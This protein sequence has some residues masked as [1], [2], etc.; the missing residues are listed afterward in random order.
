MKTALRTKTRQFPKNMVHH[1]QK[2]IW[3][4]SRGYCAVIVETAHFISA[5]DLFIYLFLWLL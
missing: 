5:A 3:F 1:E 2:D 4:S